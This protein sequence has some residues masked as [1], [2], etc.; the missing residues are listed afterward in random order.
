MRIECLNYKYSHDDMQKN[1]YVFS[2]RFIGN[3]LFCSRYMRTECLNYKYSHDDMLPISRLI[4]ALGNKM[5]TCTQRY[6][7]RPYGVGLLV[8]GYDV[9]QFYKSNFS[10]DASKK[11]FTFCFFIQKASFA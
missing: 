3:L 5:Q 9:R 2:Q 4:S 11:K 10:I 8:A 6:N 1:L 7:R